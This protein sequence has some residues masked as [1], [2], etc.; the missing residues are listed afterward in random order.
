MPSASTASASTA[1]SSS[2]ES[3]GRLRSARRPLPLLLA[4][5][6]RLLQLLLS[7]LL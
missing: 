7:L 6:P 5:L 4:R 1:A 3:T 2:V